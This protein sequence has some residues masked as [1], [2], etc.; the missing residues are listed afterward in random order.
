LLV[1]SQKLPAWSDTATSADD[2][3]PGWQPTA[4]RNGTYS[5]S[6][7]YHLVLHGYYS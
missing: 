3:V 5:L 4:G 6:E 7:R 2:M 1:I